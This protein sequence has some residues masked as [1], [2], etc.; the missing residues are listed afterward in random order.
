MTVTSFSHAGGPHGAYED[1]F[2][3]TDKRGHF[4]LLYHVYTTEP[5][6]TCTNSTVSAHVYS[7]DGFTWHAVSR[8]FVYIGMLIV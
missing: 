3:F 6:D 7:K 5:E 1:P 2:L 8:R 4:H